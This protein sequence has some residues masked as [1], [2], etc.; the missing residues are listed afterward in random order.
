MNP[1]VRAWTKVHQ[2]RVISALYCVIYT[3]L[4]GGISALNNAGQRDQAL[5]P[6]RDADGIMCSV[7][8]EM[9]PVT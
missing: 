2:P 6:L 3:L 1:F 5:E 9:G 8:A 7:P 4:L